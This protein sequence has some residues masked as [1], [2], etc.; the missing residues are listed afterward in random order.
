MEEAL[1]RQMQE[2]IKVRAEYN[3]L[4]EKLTEANRLY[5][6]KD[7]EYKSKIV[8]QSSQ[9]L[10]L[11][12]EN[13]LLKKDMKAT[14]RSDEA[15]KKKFVEDSEQIAE[16]FEKLE[17]KEFEMDKKLQKYKDELAAA[18]RE[19]HLRNLRVET[20]EKEVATLHFR[21]SNDSVPLPKHKGKLLLSML[22]HGILSSFV[23][24]FLVE[25]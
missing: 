10:L 18:A 9:I 11:N 5:L 12:N 25:I 16:I 1:Q 22:F 19:L 21:L 2:V 17:S 23:G 24:F 20:L 15:R 4:F 7:K 13:A 6:E 8:E 3:N 14:K